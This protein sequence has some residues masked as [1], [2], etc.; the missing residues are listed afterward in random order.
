MPSRQ[1]V[2]GATIGTIC[3]SGVLNGDGVLAVLPHTAGAG[4]HIPG[5]ARKILDGRRLLLPCVVE[6]SG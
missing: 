5:H 1:F 3:R 6:G 4:D 2:E